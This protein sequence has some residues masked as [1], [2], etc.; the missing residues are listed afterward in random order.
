MSTFNHYIKGLSASIFA[1]CVILFSA[2]FSLTVSADEAEDIAR[3]KAQLK[4][5]QARIVEQREHI[6]QQQDQLGEIESA[7]RETEQKV[8]QAARALHQTQIEITRTQAQI[9][10]LKNQLDDL[11]AEQQKQLNILKKQIQSAYQLGEQDF[12]KMLLNQQEAGQIERMLSYYQYFNQAR[13]KAIEALAEVVAQIKEK[14][15]VLSEQETSLI[16]LK[17]LQIEKQTALKN[18]EAAQQTSAKKLQQAIAAGSQQI[19]RLQTNQNALNRAISEL[20]E[21]LAA[22]PEQ[23]ELN[24]LQ[25]VKGRLLW[26]SEGKVENLFGQRRSGQVRWKGSRILA[27]S[28]SPV[29]SV[30]AGQVVFADWLNGYGLVIVVDHGKGFMT[31]YG[32]NQTVLK[33]VGNRV[34]TGEPVA[35]AGQSGGQLQSGVYFEIRYQGTP[36]NPSQWCR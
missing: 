13:I 35:L 1:G 16:A 8:A 2:T 17:D 6:S 11:S 24:G 15:K 5:V 12:L 7:L 3:K 18:T 21:A 25:Q 31:L 33:E 36:L 9:K 22:M 23:V 30:Y 32:N 34:Q 29:R 14:Q 20:Q 28:G 26:P 19:E 4:Q 10:H 27:D